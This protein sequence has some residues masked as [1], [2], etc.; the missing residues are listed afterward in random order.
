MGWT[1]PACHT[2]TSSFTEIHT[3]TYQYVADPGGRAV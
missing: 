3:G 2:G 1:V